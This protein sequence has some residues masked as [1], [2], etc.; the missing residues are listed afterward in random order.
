MTEPNSAP[1]S[2]WKFRT[3]L[4]AAI[5]AGLMILVG[6]ASYSSGVQSAQGPL[7]AQIASLTATVTNQSSRLTRANKTQNN[8][9]KAVAVLSEQAFAKCRADRSKFEKVLEANTRATFTTFLIVVLGT[10]QPAGGGLNPPSRESFAA[11]LQATGVYIAAITAPDKC[12]SQL[13]PKL[14]D[15]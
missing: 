5:V 14:G 8:L 2:Y 10:H 4:K 13:P 9:S 12:A 15:N 7:Q 6:S 3:F 11:Y 1:R